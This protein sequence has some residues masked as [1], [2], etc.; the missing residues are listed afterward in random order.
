MR[1]CKKCILP[2]SM[3][4]IHFDQ[5]GVCNY[6]NNHNKITYKGRDAL[7]KLVAPYRS[8]HG[9]PD[10]ILAFSGGRDSA[11]GLHYLKKEMGMNPIAFTYDWG[12]VTDIARRNQARIVGKLGVEHIIVAADIDKKRRN[13]RKNISA[14][15]KRPDPGMVTLFMAG[16]K[17]CE[18]FISDIA[19]KNNIKL[20]FF[21]RGNMLENEEFKWGYCGIK[22]GSP[23]GVLH[24]LSLWG[25]LKIL[26]FF[27]KEYLLNPSYINISIGDTLFAY[28]VTYMMRL[29]FTYLWHYIPW[30]EQT[31]VT[32]LKQEYG[33]ETEPDTL[34]T[35][36]T[37]DGT[38]PFYNYIYNAI[39][40]FTENDTFRSNQIREGM[41]TREEALQLVKEENKPRATALKWYFDAVG[42][43]QKKVLAAIDAIPKRY[44]PSV[45][46][47]KE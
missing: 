2:E 46:L 47:Y 41:L 4:L 3:P 14:W 11:Y 17:Q 35:W 19:K 45:P 21:C 5:Y 30:N 13:I 7:E 10:C 18:Y 26:S 25:K 27:A 40:G 33:W 31:I 39:G 44:D 22:N 32:T 1:Y 9:E 12:V 15:L 6:C 23:S 34:Q 24:N 20:I 37:D 28:W 38:S 43:D 36:R 29:D 16:D 42:L 8:K